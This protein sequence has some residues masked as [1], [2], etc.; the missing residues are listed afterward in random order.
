MKHKFFLVMAL[1]LCSIA[2]SAQWTK[3]EPVTTKAS[4]FKA[5]EN[6]SAATVHYYLWNT[7]YKAFLT[8][9][10]DWGTRGTL[11]E[12]GCELYLTKY[13]LEG[14]NSYIINIYTKA[15]G[16]WDRLFIGAGAPND[17]YVDWGDRDNG[18][19]TYW[20]Y[21]ANGDAL[22][23]Y[24]GDANTEYN[25]TVQGRKFYL[26]KPKGDGGTVA[27]GN[28][29]EEDAIDFMAVTKSDYDAYATA[30]ANYK[31]AVSLGEAIALS[32]SKYEGINLDVVKAV[33]N[34]PSSTAAELAAAESKIPQLEKDHINSIIGEASADNPVDMTSYIVNPNYDG[35]VHGWTGLSTAWHNQIAEIWNDRT[36]PYDANQTIN[37]LPNGIYEVNVHS[38]HRIGNYGD[39]HYASGELDEYSQHLRTSQVYANEMWKVNRELCEEETPEPIEGAGGQYIRM[40]NGLIIPDGLEYA[41]YIFNVNDMYDNSLFVNVT[42]GKLKIGVRCLDRMAFS[43]TPIETWRLHYYGTGAD[44]IELM[45]QNLAK[46]LPGYTGKLVAASLMAAYNG[47]I[48]KMHDAET[49]AEVQEAYITAINL[50]YD[51]EKNKNAYRHY[52]E[53][54]QSIIPQTA[55]LD[56][57]DN[58]ILVEYLTSNIEGGY[59][60]IVE[61]ATL[62]T[63]GLQQ[64]EQWLAEQLDKAIK[65]TETE[66]YKDFT[67]LIVNHDWSEGDMKGWNRENMDV[68]TIVSR[69]GSPLYWVSELWDYK[70]FDLSQ[71]LTEMPQGIYEVTMPALYRN[72]ANDYNHPATAEIY[73]NDLSKYVMKVT[74]D[75]VTDETAVSAP[76]DYNA[77][78]TL[79]G[80]NCFI[81]EGS[82][83][84]VWPQDWKEDIDGTTMYWPGSTFGASVAFA[85]G[86]YIN[87]VYGIV[88]ED[89]VLR[90]GVRSKNVTQGQQWLAMGNVTLRYMGEADEAIEGLKQEIEAQAEAFLDTDAYCYQGYKDEIVPALAALMNC[91]DYAG[92]IEGITKI[93]EIYA[94]ITQSIDLY[95]QLQKACSDE[96]SGLYNVAARAV[97]YGL[98]DEAT[99]EAMMQEAEGYIIGIIEGSFTNEEVIEILDKIHSNPAIDI[100]YVRGGLADG[101]NNGPSY[102]YPLKKNEEGKYV[103]LVSFNDVRYGNRYGNRNDFEMVFQGDHIVSDDN[104]TRFLLND[105]KERKVKRVDGTYDVFQCF[106]GDWIF[107]VDL[108]AMT[109]TAVPADDNTANMHRNYIV[110]AGNLAGGGGGWNNNW[111][112][113]TRWVIPHQGNDVYQGSIAYAD[114]VG[115]GGVTLYVTDPDRWGWYE[116]RVGSDPY[117]MAIE[118]GQD[119]ICHR[120]YGDRKWTMDPSHNY[121]VTYDSR[122]NIVRF[123]AH[124]LQGNGVEGDPYLLSTREDLLMMNSYMRCGK[125]IYFALTNDIDVAGMGWHALN[126]PSGFGGT[127]YS[128]QIDFD[129]RGH[130]IIGFQGDR[131]STA[132]I[133]NSFFGVVVGAVRNVAFL[134]CN[135]TE[136][137]VQME[138]LNGEGAHAMSIGALA[139]VLGHSSY[140]EETVIEN[141]V[142]MGSLTGGSSYAGAL[143]GSIGGPVSIKNSYAIADI[144]SYS[145]LA[146]GLVGSVKDVLKMENVYFAGTVLANGANGYALVAGGQDD[147]VQNGN[148]TNLVNW[149]ENENSLAV[150][151]NDNVANLYTF[152]GNNF[153]SLQQTVVNFDP[154]VWSCSM[155]EGE[156]PTLKMFAE[157]ITGIQPTIDNFVHTTS[158]KV[159]DMSGRLVSKPVHGLYII[160][161]KKTLVK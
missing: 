119:I 11:D 110:A 120:Y 115:T 6:A 46:N 98:A 66:G 132:D 143:A 63:E 21:E 55:D 12:A 86:R 114:G 87:K 25:E 153:S 127:P 161:G 134:D 27:Y 1:L 93:N 22:R 69:T 5:Y 117:E 150:R 116:S 157:L 135:I 18:G 100:I 76:A 152:D 83:H 65:N 148:Y 129:G 37:N 94:K 31:A 50:Y 68:P 42:D 81:T 28:C 124:D 59:L 112:N 49:A 140:N 126:G 99:A 20:Q 70:R 156:Y 7:E 108:E 45:K 78:T 103:G 85:G 123:D 79:D 147:N 159:Y 82:A 8:E 71:T 38:L 138:Q 62:D 91:K 26:G 73:I 118:S 30:L 23:F 48:D 160:N 146:G 133:N 39:A 125:K 144:T 113:T 121:L 32:E 128:R 52:I 67:S 109:L 29:T 90:L 142:V 75:A 33:Y 96:D 14:T 9:G 88:G 139:G 137:K 131:G 10:N 130:A 16:R 24:A 74:E 47:A 2:A 97:E 40:N 84:D 60:D 89:G 72:H 35:D 92:V 104:Y 3:P 136:D 149:T 57:E 155:A 95:E 107:T 158:G 43:W 34:N 44:A 53:Y 54:A 56:C 36:D 145:N 106:G 102:N 111:D 80:Y 17:L 58:D 154:A 105:G 122:N 141:V 15:K 19:T 4:D 61:N 41:T 151:S 77:W 64:A 101:S 51:I 13:N